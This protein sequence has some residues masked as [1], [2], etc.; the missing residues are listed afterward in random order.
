[1][2]E[3][4]TT[5]VQTA[6]TETTAATTSASS[7]AT[8]DQTTTTQPSGSATTQ[9]QQSSGSDAWAGLTPENL[10]IVQNKKWADTN[11]ALKAYGDLER[12]FSAKSATVDVPTDVAG[13]DWARPAD[14]DTYGYSDD[15][16]NGFKQGML[17]AKVPKAAA[18]AAHDWFVG[19][20]KDAASKAAEARNTAIAESKVALVREWG[21]EEGPTFARNVELSLR[22][23]EQLGL[24]DHLVKSGALIKS[25][26]GKYT[27]VDAA[28]VQAFSKVG[29]AMFAEDNLYGPVTNTSANPFALATENRT[30]AG[31][32]VKENPQLAKQLIHQSGRQAEFAMTLSKLG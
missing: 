10:S 9:G 20:A 14:A 2:T 17:G 16:A 1:M 29:S 3:A 4:T 15:F 6:S 12:A 13:Y 22:A 27:V 7:Q 32:I 5:P 18:Q 26:D 24:S 31:R 28:A 25:A 19:Y 8:G 30:L 23:T 11:A 21:P